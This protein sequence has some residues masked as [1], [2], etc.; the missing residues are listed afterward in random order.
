MSPK[1]FSDVR[2]TSPRAQLVP[3][4]KLHQGTFSSVQN[5]V[6]SQ[7]LISKL[8]ERNQRGKKTVP[9]PVTID[10]CFSLGYSYVSCQ[11]LKR[12]RFAS[13]IDTQKSKTLQQKQ[14][15]CER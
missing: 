8:Y 6:E 15:R 2:E 9:L 13:S 5:Q 1:K 11:H 4:I 3:Q 14:K 12:G 7:S 10:K